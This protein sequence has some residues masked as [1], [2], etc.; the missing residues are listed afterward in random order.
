MSID[1]SSKTTRHSRTTYLKT[2]DDEQDGKQRNSKQQNEFGQ[3]GEAPEAAELSDIHL[4]QKEGGQL[5][6][7][8]LR[9]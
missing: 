6:H 7:V 9:N 3:I 4:D 1:Y 2:D 8:E 5:E